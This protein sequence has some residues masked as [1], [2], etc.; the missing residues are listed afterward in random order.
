MFD[1]SIV[2]KYTT[3]LLQG[4]WATTWISLVS[5][6]IGFGL[7]LGLYALGRSKN[8]IVYWLTRVYVSF[9]RGTPLIVQLAIVFY[10][11]PLI[12]IN[13]PPILAAVIGL[14]MNTG[15]FQSEILRGGFSSLP[16][17]QEESCWVLG[18]TPLQGFFHVKLP[19][20]IRVTTPAL[21]NESIDIIK[22]SSLISTI[23]VMDLMRVVQTSSSTTFRFL[24]FT[25]AAGA[26]YLVLTSIVSVFGLYVE[27][28][29][30]VHERHL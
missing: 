29:L 5:I 10:F 27:R 18:L 11:L 23:A 7:G 22:N 4:L 3:P 15:A 28:K 26:L 9:F 30:S 25:L 2:F 17:G 21:V 13:V 20:V 16:K 19:Q 12:G 1:F 24:E 14:S 6:L 8:P